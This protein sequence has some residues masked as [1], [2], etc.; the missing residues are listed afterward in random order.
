MRIED[1]QF[2]RGDALARLARNTE[3]ER[4]FREEIRLFPENTDAY[5]RL[6]VLYAV[7]H[8]LVK[9]VYGVLEAMYSA[10]PTPATA[11]LAAKTLE[12]VGD[13][14]GAARWRSRIT[15]RDTPRP[16]NMNR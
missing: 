15:P 11:D 14:A 16:A 6:A 3:A 8:R 5:A 9:E 4:A 10:S 12:S 7:D 1:A 2:L 13:P